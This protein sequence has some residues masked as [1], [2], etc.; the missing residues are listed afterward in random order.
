MLSSSSIVTFSNLKQVPN[1]A[2]LGLF[3]FASTTFI[4]SLYNVNAH[5]VILPNVVVGMACFCGGL[6][7]LLAGMNLCAHRWLKQPKT[8]GTADEFC[9]YYGSL[10]EEQRKDYDNVANVSVPG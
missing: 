4:L 7:Q 3:S 6:A 2:A 1:P 5:G 9:V 10:N 8:N